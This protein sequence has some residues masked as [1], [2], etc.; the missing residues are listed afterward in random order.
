MKESVTVSLP[1]DFINEKT[2][3]LGS[4]WVNFSTPKKKI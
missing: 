1:S 3:V 2:K 4:Y